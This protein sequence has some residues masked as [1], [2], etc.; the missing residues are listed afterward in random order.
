MNKELQEKLFL[1]YP[2]IFRQKSLTP[3][4][5]AMCY[6]IG[7][8]DG[9]FDLLDELCG[10]IQNRCE[11]I[12]RNIRYKI[13]NSQSDEVVEEPITFIC[14]ATQ[15]KEKFGGLRFYTFGG[16]DFIDGAISLAESMSYRI[17][18]KCGNKKDTPSSDRGWIHS[19]CKNCQDEF[20]KSRKNNN[21]GV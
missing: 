11:N 1:K 14:E 18:S 13:E 20:L 10:E 8:G 12:N 3:Q 19:T 6:G 21:C 2:K 9:W 15:V 4:E 17:C 5:T 16:D 7:C